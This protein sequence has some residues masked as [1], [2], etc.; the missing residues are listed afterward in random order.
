MKNPLFRLA[1]VLFLCAVLTPARAAPKDGSH[2]FD[3]EIGVWDTQVKLLKRPLTGSTEWVEFQGK[4]TVREVLGGK[5]NMVELSVKNAAGGGIEGASLRL[6]DP[7]ARQWSLNFFNT[8]DG[9]LTPPVFGE[10]SEGRGLFYGSDTLNGRA[11]FVRFEIIKVKDGVYRFE[12]AFSADG[13]KTWELN[14][15]ATDTLNTKKAG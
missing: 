10:F 7:Q 11:I 13:G 15:I 1:L 4:S 14:W 8:A 6:Y 9:H 12:Q 3:F 2:D 5:A